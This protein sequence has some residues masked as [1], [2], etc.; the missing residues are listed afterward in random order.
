M[1][2]D[3]DEGSFPVR[4]RLTI[5]EIEEA[6]AIEQKLETSPLEAVGEAKA[7]IVRLIQ[8]Q[9]P[10]APVPKLYMEDIG[11][12]LAALAGNVS[13]AQELIDALAGEASEDG[14]GGG[15]A[16][17]AE[18]ETGA[19]EAAPLASKKR[20]SK[21]SS[22]S[23]GSTAGRRAGGTAASGTTSGSTSKKRVASKA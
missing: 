23:G 15:T 2:L 11:A 7:L 14:E 8:E 21:R 4:T 20:S 16:A 6:L 18:S 19:G 9:T 17:G 3:F 10:K 12:I 22:R 1:V 5:D 13:V